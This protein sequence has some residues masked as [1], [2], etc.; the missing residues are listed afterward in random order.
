MQSSSEDTTAIASKAALSTVTFGRALGN[1]RGL[2]S[3]QRLQLLQLLLVQLD[4]VLRQAVP[5]SALAR[6]GHRCPEHL[7]QVTGWHTHP[8]LH[9]ARISRSISEASGAAA[10]SILGWVTAHNLEQQTAMPLACQQQRP[11]HMSPTGSS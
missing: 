10:S 8:V 5:D 3:E 11:M 6:R 4:G 9:N 2:L 7:L 1:R